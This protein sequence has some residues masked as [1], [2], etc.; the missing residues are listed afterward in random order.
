MPT[1]ISKYN[2]NC[3]LSHRVQDFR[4]TVTG[5]NP[6]MTEIPVLFTGALVMYMY[7]DKVSILMKYLTSKPRGLYDLF[8]ETSNH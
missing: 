8:P 6:V 1:A 5:L 2:R 3:D 4:S 7:F